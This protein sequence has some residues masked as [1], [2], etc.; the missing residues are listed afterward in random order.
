MFI[1]RTQKPEEIIE[2]GALFW[3]RNKS[4]KVK[5]NV[6]FDIAKECGVQ[7]VGFTFYD[8]EAAPINNYHQHCVN[9]EVKGS[10]ENLRKFW[11]TN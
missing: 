4:Y 5:F 7:I 1:K 3:K 8:G 6:L 11:E 2:F 10:P 9:F